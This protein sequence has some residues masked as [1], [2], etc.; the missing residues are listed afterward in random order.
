LFCIVIQDKRQFELTTAALSRK[1]LTTAQDF[2]AD[3]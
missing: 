1:L 3:W 2:Y